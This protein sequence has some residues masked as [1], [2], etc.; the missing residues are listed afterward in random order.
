MG[1]LDEF[2]LAGRRAVV[3]GA[4]KGIGRG[5]AL[6]LAEAGADVVVSART[7]ADVDA[8][9]ADIAALGRTGVAVTDVTNADDLA[10]LADTAVAELGGIDLWVNN[11]G[12]LPDAT[13]RYLTKTSPEQFAKQIDLNL[14]A[15]WAAS[16]AAAT[17][18]TDGGSIINISSG[19]AVGPQLKNGPYGA[20]KAAVNSLTQTLSVELAPNIRVNAVSPGPVPTENFVESTG[21]TG[22]RVEMIDKQLRIPLGRLGT[23]RDI[24]AAVVFLASPAAS[25][26]TGQV[27]LVNGGR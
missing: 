4:G 12:G 2:S 11:A 25:W 17:R 19:S 20:S 21:Y 10:R 6:C 8:V 22:D 15:V 13:P 18:M 5:I 23:D 3:T 16:V 27:L 1:V 14:T 9:A 26:V 7:A 24:G